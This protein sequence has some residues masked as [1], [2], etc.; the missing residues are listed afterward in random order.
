MNLQGALAIAKECFIGF[1]SSEGLVV[2][3]DGAEAGWARDLDRPESWQPGC[4]AINSV[5]KV[6]EAVGG[7]NYDGA[8]QWQ[9][10]KNK[11]QA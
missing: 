7:N 6:W 8:E 11:E 10:V 9:A 3:F 1:E 5:G 2:I 4:L